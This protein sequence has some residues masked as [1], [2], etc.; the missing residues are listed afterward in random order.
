MSG[1]L[2]GVGVGPGDPDLLTLKAA[3]LLAKVPV[4]AW[5]APLEGPGMARTIAAAAIPDGK[6][7]I[8][9]RM[10]F[11]PERDDT[12]QAYDNAAAAIAAHLDAGRDVAV[13]CEGD[14]LFFGSFIYLLARLSPAYPVEVVPGVSSPMAAAALLRQPLTALDDSL[15]IIPATK[16]E[17]EIER[18]LAGAD[19]AVVMKVG[20][21]LPKLRRVLA[22][23]GLEAGARVVER[24]G[25]DGER[26]LSLDQAT[27]AGPIYFSLILIHRAKEARP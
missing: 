19:A 6:I 27:L 10:A 7:E 2:Y 16:S 14:P 3:R 17:A 21:H 15:A 20:R 4:V 18:L 13:L 8:A 9:I 24:V 23:L 5:P 22:R 25:L 12:D 11:R 1:I 26:V